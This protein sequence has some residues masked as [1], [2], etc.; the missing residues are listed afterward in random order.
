MKKIIFIVFSLLFYCQISFSSENLELTPR[1][2]LA[3]E[4]ER[5]LF[6]LKQHNEFVKNLS[7]NISLEE[8]L[9]H[10]RKSD[11]LYKKY[12]ELERIYL[13]SVLMQGIS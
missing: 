7:E 5:T 13:M 3:Q 8:I 6:A 4:I 11:K 9:Y 2:Y 1:E 10:T 12:C